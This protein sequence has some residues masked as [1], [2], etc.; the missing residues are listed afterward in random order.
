[1][2][3][4]FPWIS[5]ITPEWASVAANAVIASIT[6][7][8]LVVTSCV[9][10]EQLRLTREQVELGRQTVQ[11]EMIY[12]MQRDARQA[13]ADYSAGRI[14]ANGLFPVMHSIY[15]QR[16]YLQTIPNPVWPIFEQDF[17]AILSREDVRRAWGVEPRSAYDPAFIAY[18]G[19][20]LTSCGA[21]R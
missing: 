7:I 21:A 16:Q 18:M 14:R 17:C 13:G 9:S 2:A 19:E 5:A 1:M 6:L 3:R 8:A 4:N 15:L 11:N 20:T 12:N 10:V